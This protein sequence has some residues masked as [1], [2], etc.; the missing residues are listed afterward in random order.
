[1]KIKGATRVTVAKSPSAI[2]RN[3]DREPEEC[4]CGEQQ[5]RSLSFR[6]PTNK[7][8]EKTAAVGR[9]NEVVLAIV[10]LGNGD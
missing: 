7:P 6:R 2:G 4:E 1:M 10:N 8:R 3:A 5:N 9:G